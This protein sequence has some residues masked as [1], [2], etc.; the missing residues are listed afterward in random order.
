M[1][2][3]RPG[4]TF[5]SACNTVTQAVNILGQLECGARYFDIR[6]VISAGQYLTGHYTRIDAINSWQGANGESIQEIVENINAYMA[7]NDELIILNLSHDLDTDLGN[8]SYAPFTQQ[9]W[10]DLL[11]LLLEGLHNLFVCDITTHPDL[12]Q[13]TLQYFIGSGRAAV[14]VIVDPS[15]TG[16]R[17]DS[18]VG[19]GFY[20]SS[21]FPIYNEYSDTNM[22]D[23]MVSDQLKKMRAQRTSPDTPC[24]LLSW[25]LTQDAVQAMACTTKLAPSIMDLAHKANAGLHDRLLPACNALCFPNILCVDDIDPSLD[26]SGLAIHINSL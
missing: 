10:N 21:F 11:T 1:S 23:R 16:I 12:T 4:T 9:Q 7:A 6:P 26:M 15:R 13:L 22:L 2:K 24:F 5:A 8:S 19:Q 25:T 20:P 18:Y 14:V 3:F 17:L